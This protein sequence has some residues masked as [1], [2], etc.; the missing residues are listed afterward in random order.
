[1]SQPE[2]DAEYR[3]RIKKVCNEE[4]RGTLHNKYGINLDAVG[5]KYDRFRYGKTLID[6]PKKD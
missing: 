3:E 2:T 1:M 5:R 4:D 6:E